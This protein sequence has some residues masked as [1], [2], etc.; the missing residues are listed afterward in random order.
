MSSSERNQMQ[1]E[2]SKIGDHSLFIINESHKLLGK[3][4]LWEKAV[5]I[6]KIAKNLHDS[7]EKK[8]YIPDTNAIKERQGWEDYYNNPYLQ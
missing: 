3:N 6:N 7:L 5:K 1:S 2:L 8:E 4:E